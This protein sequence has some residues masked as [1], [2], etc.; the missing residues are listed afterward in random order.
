MRLLSWNIRQGDELFEQLLQSFGTLI[1]C[2]DQGAIGTFTSVRRQLTPPSQ[3]LEVARSRQRPLMGREDFEIVDEKP[4]G[5]G[6]FGTV[7]RAKRRSDGG[8]A[9]LK[10]IL[11][12]G[13]NGADAIG[14][15][16]AHRRVRTESATA[17]PRR[18]GICLLFC[19]CC[20]ALPWLSPLPQW[21]AYR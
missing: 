11:R 19:S 21:F 20:P 8:T 14:G 7:F 1:S 10:L 2:Y 16:Q 9:A 4:I 3:P 18:V 12:H 6:Q 13:E 5:C 17:N 15:D